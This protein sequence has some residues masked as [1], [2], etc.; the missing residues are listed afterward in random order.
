MCAAF[1]SMHLPRTESALATTL[2]VPHTMAA[3]TYLQLGCS[4]AAE[5]AMLSYAKSVV[6]K[7]FSNAGMARSILYP[8]KTTGESFFCAGMNVNT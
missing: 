2:L 1:P 6:G 5:M 3:Y 7:P 4:K 8:R